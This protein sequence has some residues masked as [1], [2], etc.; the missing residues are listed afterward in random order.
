GTS[1]S[2][3]G[4]GSSSLGGSNPDGSS[5]TQTSLA[6]KYKNMQTGISKWDASDK[7][8]DL[9]GTVTESG[10]SSFVHR[11]QL[12]QSS[13]DLMRMEQGRKV[14]VVKFE[15]SSKEEMSRETSS[16]FDATHGVG[17]QFTIN[18]AEDKVKTNH[19]WM[20]KL[21]SSRSEHRE[22]AAPTSAPSTTMTALRTASPSASQSLL[23][24]AP[25]GSQLVSSATHTTFYFSPLADVTKT[26]KNWIESYNSDGSPN[27][28][29][30]LYRY[31]DEVK[32]NV[33]AWVE[34]TGY[35]FNGSSTLRSKSKFTETNNGT[36][37]E[38]RGLVRVPVSGTYENGYIDGVR[39]EESRSFNNG[40]PNEI[41]NSIRIQKPAADNT[42]NGQTTVAPGGEDH[43]GTSKSVTALTIQNPLITEMGEVTTATQYQPRP[44]PTCPSDARDYD[45]W[46]METFTPEDGFQHWSAIPSQYNRA[47]QLHY[48]LYGGEHGPNDH[49]AKPPVNGEI[50]GYSTWQWAYDYNNAIWG[51]LQVDE[52]D[53]Y[54]YVGGYASRQF[55]IVVG[56]IATLPFSGGAAATT[57]GGRALW[58]VYSFYAADQLVSAGGSAITGEHV[59]TIGTQAIRNLMVALGN[60]ANS[61]TTIVASEGYNYAWLPGAAKS[62]WR[63]FRNPKASSGLGNIADDVADTA[64]GSAGRKLFDSLD[65]FKAN[66][67][68]VFKGGDAEAVRAFAAYQK[69]SKAKN[70]LVIGHELDPID[71][72]FDGWQAF[73]MKGKDYTEEINWAWIDGAVDAGKPVLVATPHDKIR[74]GSITWREM[75]RVLSRGGK[76]I[77]NR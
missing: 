24:N 38:Y 19:N 27:A 62:F 54:L 16:A 63:I 39:F 31:L 34:K 17:R 71:Q 45:N 55:G 14:S 75:M 11:E 60:D 18:Q 64:I 25:S 40:Q 37:F 46:V 35:D 7:G 59:D 77:F 58:G 1:T 68:L 15:A 13:E 76:V 9:T 69:A 12:S 2:S 65:D 56:S 74:V 48:M 8:F 26:V 53:R 3:G 42:H 23:G 21:I 57:W 6:D 28:D 61:T 49:I 10:G 67:G 73:R 51:G 66:S 32:V 30:I 36:V 52:T 43:T 50:R 5:L 47:R 44:D 29:P 20:D 4:S 33:T 72:A 41:N 70:G 22:Y